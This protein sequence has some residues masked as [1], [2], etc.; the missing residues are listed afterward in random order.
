[1]A[2]QRTGGV[3]L[4]ILTALACA[5]TLFAVSCIGSSAPQS[6][7]V[8]QHEIAPQPPKVGPATLTLKLTDDSAKP[9]S[10][11]RVTL[12]SNMTHA[13]MTPVFAEAK[14]A[15]PGRYLATLE[16]NM[17]G[18]WVVLVHAA[19]PDGRKIERRLDVRGVRAN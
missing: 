6:G 1:M 11:A 18:D 2:L 5:A 19:L 7:I 15:E 12:E 14:E 4:L 10:G 3:R 13:G 9:L 16:F 17:G 8:V